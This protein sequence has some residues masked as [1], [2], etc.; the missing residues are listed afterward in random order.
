LGTIS[1]FNSE[2]INPTSNFSNEVFV[3]QVDYNKINS[4]ISLI[5]KEMREQEKL[6]TT[7]KFVDPDDL[8]S[9]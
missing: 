8:P 9:D 4:S 7:R 2:Q 3:K 5:K 6:S 1:L